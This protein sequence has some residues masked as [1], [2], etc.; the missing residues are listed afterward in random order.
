MGLFFFF[1]AI[2][3]VC[4]GISFLCT[5][6]E[7]IAAINAKIKAKKKLKEQKKLVKQVKK[8]TWIFP[9]NDFVKKCAERGIFYLKTESDY[10]KAK[11]IA[12]DILRARGVPTEYHPRYTGRQELISYIADLSKQRDEELRQQEQQRQQQQQKL[13]DADLALEKMYTQYA[14]CTGKQ[15]S[16]SICKDAIAD[17]ERI[18]NE[19]SLDLKSVMQGGNATY[20]SGKQHLSSW[21][22]HGG[23]ASGI[24]GGA[25]GVAVAMDV[26]RRNRAKQ[27]QNENL[28]KAVATVAVGKINQIYKRRSEAEKQLEYWKQELEKSK[29]L[30]AKKVNADDLLDLLHPMV[31]KT[32][33]TEAG[34]V[35]LKVQLDSTPNLKILDADAVVDGSFIV[36]L[37]D[38]NEVVG[39]AICSL[40]Y[41]GATIYRKVDCICTNI[42]KA[43]EEY[44]FEFLPHNLWLIETNDHV[45]YVK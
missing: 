30:R 21:A 1:A 3:V 18:I 26:A 17:Y 40:P 39:K 37:K 12:V 44:T 15:K 29:T 36:L 41:G 8:N 27:E 38:G 24:A 20:L 23:I 42:L 28:A 13:R 11:S 43:T 33:P 6:S 10:Q 25:A 5:Y 22:I 34:G 7:E 32:E 16:I 4:G 35:K 31:V 19:C 45:F 14:N 2:A 9:V